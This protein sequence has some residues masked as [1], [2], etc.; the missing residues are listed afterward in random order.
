MLSAKRVEREKRPGRYLD[1][2][3]LYLQVVNANNRSWIFRY[4]RDGRERQMGLGPVH[5]V[6]LKLAREKAQAARLLLLDDIDPLAERE[7]KKAAI[8]AAAAKTLT[9]REAAQQYIDQHER[10]WSAKH[11]R[12]WRKT[13]EQHAF[14]VLGNMAVGD[15]DTAAVLRVIDPLWAEKT[16][17]AS[18]VRGR[19]ESILDWATVRG[20]RQGDNPAR[21][22]GRLEHVLPAKAKVR[23]VEH[24]AALPYRDVPA[25]MAALADRQGSAARALEFTILTAARSGEVT[26]ATWGEIDLEQRVWIV[27][28]SRMKAKKEHR[29]PLSAAAVELLQALPSEQG[30]PHLFVGAQRGS[31]L[32]AAAMGKLLVRMK[33][34]DISVHGFRST[35]RDWAGETTNFPNH[36]VEMALAHTIPSAVEKA[37]RRGDLFVKRV[38]LMEAWAQFCSKPAPAGVVLPMRKKMR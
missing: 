35:F 23:K 3:G 22:T 1:Q 29:V 34:A 37:Y 28:A 25:F 21:W 18:R 33:R 5:T 7:A 17:T 9:F 24:H 16:E 11:A 30:N 6:S 31:G 2:H 20:Y 4:E 8:A 26:G 10:G 13:L 36:V 27:P 15:V 38:K 19:I 32:S 12:Q 14:K